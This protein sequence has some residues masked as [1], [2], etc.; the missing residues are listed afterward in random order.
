MASTENPRAGSLSS[1]HVQV[2]ACISIGERVIFRCICRKN[3][4]H[5]EFFEA[6]C[7]WLPATRGA[8]L[9]IL[10]MAMGSGGPGTT[11]RRL[12]RLRSATPTG[13]A[14]LGAFSALHRVGARP[15]PPFKAFCCQHRSCLILQVSTSCPSLDEPAARAHGAPPPPPRGHLLPPIRPRA[16]ARADAPAAGCLS[17]SYLLSVREQ[18]V[19]TPASVFPR[20]QLAERTGRASALTVEP[21]LPAAADSTTGRQIRILLC[22]LS[23]NSDIRK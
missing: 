18:I 15:W 7:G 22:K 21:A 12:Q 3:L 8:A 20:E 17:A 1:S 11:V 14:P 2:T 13:C 9:G 19:D 10:R 23:L 6:G 5:S 16:L 4:A